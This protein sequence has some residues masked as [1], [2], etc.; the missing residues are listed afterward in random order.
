MV[1][2]RRE[3]WPRWV[4][5]DGEEPDYRFSLA[6]ERTF[7][8]WIRSSPALLGAGVAIDAVDLDISAGMQRLSAGILVVLGILAAV[9]AWLRWAAAE[10]AV[11]TGTQ[12]PSL[13][14]TVVIPLGLILA[15]LIVV[16]TIR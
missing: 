14:F 2:K 11:R 5:R 10:R 1:V 7:L 3:R 8:A 12:L 15:A 9:A 13:A 4:Y 6:I 16:L